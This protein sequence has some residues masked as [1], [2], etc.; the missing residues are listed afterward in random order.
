MV[1]AEVVETEVV[2]EVGKVGKV[3]A[4]VEAE[5]VAEVVAEGEAEG[6]GE[7]V[8]EGGGGGRQLA[9]LTRFL[10]SSG[11]ILPP[12]LDLT[13]PS[14]ASSIW[15]STMASAFENSDTPSTELIADTIST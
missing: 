8:A 10:A 1:E 14:R 12:S 15:A 9:S 4:V 5:V 13:P 3:E 2:V 7:V 11:P 6:E